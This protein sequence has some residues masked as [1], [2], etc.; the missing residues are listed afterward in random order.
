MAHYHRKYSY[1]SNKDNVTK[2]IEICVM[3]LN[4]IVRDD[5]LSNALTQHEAKWGEVEILH[6]KIKDTKYYNIDIKVPGLN[7]KDEKVETKN[8]KEY[9]RSKRTY[10][11]TNDF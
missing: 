11:S 5:Y 6:K 8:I 7:K 2:Q 4:R 3:L 9:K 1:S 10:F